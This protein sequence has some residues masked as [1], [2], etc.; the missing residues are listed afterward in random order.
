MERSKLIKKLKEDKGD[1]HQI[2]FDS[3]IFLEKT[4]HELKVDFELIE[5]ILKINKI[6]YSHEY[7]TLKKD[8]QKA[9][10]EYIK[11]SSK[12]LKNKETNPSSQ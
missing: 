7:S 10:N 3:R 8:L 9:Y 5:E 11:Y 12:K 2:A 4:C 6:P 1:P